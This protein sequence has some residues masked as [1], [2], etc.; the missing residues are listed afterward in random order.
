MTKEPCFSIER[1]GE[2]I[3]L[4]EEDPRRRH[5]GECPRCRALFAAYAEFRDPGTDFPAD[6]VADAEKRM[7]EALR[8]AI[9]GPVEA[10]KGPARTPFPGRKERPRL[11]RFLRPAALIAAGLLIVVVGYRVVEQ[12]GADD[13]PLV[14]RGA[15][16]EA[17][18]PVASGIEL[19]Q[20]VTLP[21][22]GVELRWVSHE[23]TGA[24][25]VHLYTAGIEEITPAR[26]VTEARLVV[27][28]GEIARGLAPGTVL[29]WRV[30]ALREGDE[31]ALSPL[32][33]FQV[34]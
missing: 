20:P 32:G 13:G 12:R 24:Y 14:L 4:P 5:L 31:V 19:E 6:D 34:P 2:L 28:P 29:L 3:D 30:A 8:R 18:A 15:R 11:V 23:E 25:R 26:D 21:D 16:E 27:R 1:L 22:R 33:S 10:G 9:E 17:E 7:R